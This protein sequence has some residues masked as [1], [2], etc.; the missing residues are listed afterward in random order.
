ML[1]KLLKRNAIFIGFWLGDQSV[2]LVSWI[3]SACDALVNIR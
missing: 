1:E 2:L 3:Q